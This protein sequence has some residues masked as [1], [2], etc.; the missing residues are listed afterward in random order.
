MDGETDLSHEKTDTVP[1]GDVKVR[2]VCC[3]KT[4]PIYVGS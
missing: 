3:S 4:T 1:D 2:P